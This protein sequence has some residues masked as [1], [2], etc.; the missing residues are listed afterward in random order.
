MIF[1][2][3]KNCVIKLEEHSSFFHKKIKSWLGVN[4]YHHLGHFRMLLQY[5]R[6]QTPGRSFRILHDVDGKVMISD[7]EERLRDFFLNCSAENL[8]NMKNF[9]KSCGVKQ[10]LF[11]TGIIYRGR[12]IFSKVLQVP[13]PSSLTQPTHP[14]PTLPT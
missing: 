3:V 11:S 5:Y 14:R 1:L 10:K 8:L 12:D 2:V 9:V 6:F 4:M 13:C 7:I